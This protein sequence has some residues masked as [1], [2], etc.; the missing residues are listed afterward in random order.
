MTGSIAHGVVMQ[1]TGHIIGVLSDPTLAATLQPW[2]SEIVRS[3][4]NW[5]DTVSI[6]ESF[7]SATAWK[8]D[9]DSCASVPCYGQQSEKPC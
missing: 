9:A 2:R 3:G 4:D 7:A 5:A 6:S 8:E 1:L